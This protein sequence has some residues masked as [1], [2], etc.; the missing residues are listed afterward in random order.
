MFLGHTQFLSH[1]QL[2]FLICLSHTL[3]CSNVR[4]HTDTSIPACLP[5][6][7]PVTAVLPVSLAPFYSDWEETGRWAW[8]QRQHIRA[9]NGSYL[10]PSSLLI[11]GAHVRARNHV[12]TKGLFKGIDLCIVFLIFKAQSSKHPLCSLSWSHSLL[13]LRPHWSPSLSWSFVLEKQNFEVGITADSVA[14][15]GSIF[16]HKGFL[17]IKTNFWKTLMNAW[18]ATV[19]Q[20]S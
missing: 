19:C 10:S 6:L 1:V 18:S 15:S 17:K 4:T 9:S 7:C 8:S 5:L 20:Y 12:D 3:Q 2:S 14:Q 13:R 16:K 11:A